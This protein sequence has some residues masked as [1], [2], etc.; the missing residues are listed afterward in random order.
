MRKTWKRLIAV[1]L[2]GLMAV[3]LTAC[4]NAPAPSGDG[5]G[6]ISGNVDALLWLSSYP[7][8]AD[9]MMAEFEKKYPNISVDLNMCAGDTLAQNYE[10]RIASGQ[11][12]EVI[13]VN[14]DEWSMT[15]ADKGYLAD[16]GSTQA[17]QKQRR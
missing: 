12:P 17:F 15:N 13:S 7:Q 3:G 11:M 9:E 10:P 5:D 8:Y 16:I 2:V 4:D 1:G 14:Y 6:G